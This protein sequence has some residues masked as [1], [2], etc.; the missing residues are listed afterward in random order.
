MISEDAFRALSSALADLELSTLRSIRSPSQAR[1]GFGPEGRPLCFNRELRRDYDANDGMT[2]VV[3]DSVPVQAIRAKRI[4]WAFSTD[5]KS[6]AADPSTDPVPLAEG[7]KC[8]GCVHYPS[9]AVDL[10]L[11]RRHDRKLREAK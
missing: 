5:C 8:G 6:W 1:Q 2:T 4:P 7:W 9:E 11:T 10:A 3:V